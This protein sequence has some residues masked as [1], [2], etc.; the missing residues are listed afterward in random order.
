MVPAKPFLLV[1]VIVEFPLPPAAKVSEEG[2]AETVK[3]PVGPA[4]V[5][6]IATVV[7]CTSEPLDPVTWTE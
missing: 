5:T 3:S 1:N 7:L 2:F 6:V 4:D